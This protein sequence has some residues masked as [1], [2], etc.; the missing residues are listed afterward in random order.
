MKISLYINYLKNLSVFKAV[1]KVWNL[2]KLPLKLNNFYNHIFVRFFRVLGG[3]S[4]VI[5]LGEYHI[6]LPFYLQNIIDFL[7][8]VQAAQMVFIGLIKIVYGL[9]IFKY[10]PE[11]FE[12]RN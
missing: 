3:F 6:N 8:L 11:L 10:H 1:V 7:G 12:I 5:M 9:Y 4:L 2:P